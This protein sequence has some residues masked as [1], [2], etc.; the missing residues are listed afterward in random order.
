MKISDIQYESRWCKKQP[1]AYAHSDLERHMDAWEQMQNTSF[2]ITQ[3]V[4]LAPE[5]RNEVRRDKRPVYK[6]A[7]YVTLN[8]KFIALKVQT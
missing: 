6:E 1:Q 4:K 2:V 7:K 3:T 5:R 8:Y